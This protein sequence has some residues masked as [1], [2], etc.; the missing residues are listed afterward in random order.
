MNGPLMVEVQILKGL[1]FWNPDDLFIR[2]TWTTFS[3][4]WYLNW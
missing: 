2:V 3:E 4:H 1:T